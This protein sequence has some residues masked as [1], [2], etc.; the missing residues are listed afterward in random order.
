MAVATGGTVAA[1]SASAMQPAVSAKPASPVTGAAAPPASGNAVASYA[2]AVRA[3]LPSVVLVRTADGLGS[4]VVL[5]RAGNIVT[6]AHV[7]G[8]ATSLQ[9]QLAGDPAPRPAHLVGTHP[10][11]DLAV[12]RAEN[13]AGLTPATFGDSSKAEAGDVVLAVGNP[14]GLAG[15]VTEGIISATGRAVLEPTTASTTAAA[16]P[17]AIQTSAPI[18]PGNSGG[19]LVTATGHVIGIPTL[20]AASPQGG[21]QAQGIGFAIPSNLARDIAG[22]IIK[23]GHVTNSHRA[24]LGARVTSVDGTAPGAAIVT[25]TPGGAAE[26]AGLRAGDVIRKL[27]PAPT[28]GAG[29]LMSAL[30]AA[31]PGQR[32]ELTIT[33]SGQT[34]TV[35]VTLGTLPAS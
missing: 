32:A 30:A 24:A 1:C 8:Q 31:D 12:I 18:N 2:A 3:V 13:P 33:R 21:G 17:D 22:Q 25:V 4:G 10:Q 9:I 16:L 11:G 19:A 26:R 23:S 20:A 15:S 6:N 35:A 29:A 7:A 14:L 34:H 5:D 27:G 28:P